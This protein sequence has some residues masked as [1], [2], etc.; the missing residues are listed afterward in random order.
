MSV[1]IPLETLTVADK[2]RLRE[3]VW[4]S[5]CGE[6]G[7][8]QS[9]DR[10]PCNRSLPLYPKSSSLARQGARGEVD[11]NQSLICG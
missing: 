7:D 5:L 10:Q 1:D 11:T 2:V 6:P 4:D 9:P 8:Q 3:T